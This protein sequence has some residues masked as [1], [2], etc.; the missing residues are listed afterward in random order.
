MAKRVGGGAPALVHHHTFKCAGSTFNW[1]LQ[2]NFPGNVLHVEGESDQQRITC[3]QVARHLEGSACQAVSSHLL[4]MPARDLGIGAL[5]VAFARDPIERLWSSHYFFDRRGDFDP[6]H[7]FEQFCRGSIE[8]N[9]NFQVRHLSVPSVDSWRDEEGWALLPDTIDL[10]R[11]DAFIGVVELFDESMVILEHR[12]KALGIRFNG[13]YLKPLNTSGKPERPPLSDDFT[14]FLFE[15]TRLDRRLH[16]DAT[17]RLRDAL[18]EI[19]RGGRKLRQFKRRRARLQSSLA[20]TVRVPGA[21]AWT[22]LPPE[23]TML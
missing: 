19:D 11:A 21:S 14:A 4:A 7:T 22:R 13:A 16:E 6:P 17:A 20:G 8:W 3:A 12:L 5:H 23:D 10:D 9:G 1:I 2:R 18:L 15:H